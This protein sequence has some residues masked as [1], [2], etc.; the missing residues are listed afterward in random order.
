MAKIAG[1]SILREELWKPA[2]RL[3]IVRHQPLFPPLEAPLLKSLFQKGLSRGGIVEIYGLRSSGRTSVYLHI[4]A[5]ATA[6]GEVCAVIDLNGSFHPLSAAMAGV[7]VS[8]LLW[9]RCRGNAEHAMR[10][11]DLLLHA[12]G[13]G[14]VVLDLSEASARVLNRI[15]LPY[16]YRFRSAV[17]N[18]P[19]ILIV[20]T[21]SAQVKS[22]FRQDLQLKRKVFH[23]SGKAPFLVFRGIEFAAILN[24]AR[25]FLPAPLTLQTVA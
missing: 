14:A 6:R 22:S 13:F 19:A 20:C 17:E 5:Q 9:V 10:A 8:Q 1:A 18:T 21:P 15:P 11:A 3:A 7:R 24:D 25:A 4:L 23:W 2:S 12:G 16:W